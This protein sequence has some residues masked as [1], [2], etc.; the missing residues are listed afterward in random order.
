MD[1]KN[2]RKLFIVGVVVAVLLLAFGLVNRP[3]TPANVN[4]VF[5][6]QAP[7]FVGVAK[8]E[9]VSGASFLDD[10]AGIAAYTQAPGTI[11]LSVV[12][13][14]FRTIERET[15]QYIIGSVGIP[16]YSE[17]HDPHV[18][19]HTDGW[20]L[21][22]YLAAEPASYI[23]DLRH[24]DGVSVGTTKLEDAMHEILSVIG[25]VSFETKY[26][27]F[28]YPNATHLMLIIEAIYN[29]GNESF[30][31]HLPSDF[32]YYDRSW[33]HAL[34]SY[35]YYW[36]DSKLYLDDN[37]VNS[38]SAYKGW[39]FAHGSL[40]TAQLPPGVSHTIRIWLDEGVSED[41]AFAGI[42]LVYQ[43]VQ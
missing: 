20:V 18:Y 4:N 34:S 13:D 36:A 26:Y 16:D 8:A 43:E 1:M 3:D 19:V 27:D 17:D 2:I 14:V 33:S 25:V 7:P 28:R 10:E 23:M 9:E 42:A 24:Y 22:Y 11:D 40:T 38:L 21:A 5:S 41:K 37:L 12:R 15:D 35:R 39:R 31:L 6:L 30:N 29:E 32:T